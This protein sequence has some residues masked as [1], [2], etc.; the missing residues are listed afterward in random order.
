[1]IADLLPYGSTSHNGMERSA[2]AAKAPERSPWELLGW[3]ILEQ[4]ID[5]LALFARW[6]IV[7]PRGNCLPWPHEVKRQVKWGP[8]G[9]REAWVKVPKTIAASRGPNDHRLL[10]A[11]WKS[12]DAQQLCDW[13]GC[14]LPAQEIFASTIKHHGGLQ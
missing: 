10:V 8:R 5:D 2:V 9:R 6:G 12:E 11:W 3:A 14:R 7:T 13:V 4:A 1:M